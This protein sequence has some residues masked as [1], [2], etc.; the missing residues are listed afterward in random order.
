MIQVMVCKMSPT[1][2][3]TSW[4]LVAFERSTKVGV[5]PTGKGCKSSVQTQVP[6]GHTEGPVGNIE[7]F[8]GVR[9]RLHQPY[10]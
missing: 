10:C 4:S 6:H 1:V 2:K 5:G 9:T 8:K 3:A 7:R